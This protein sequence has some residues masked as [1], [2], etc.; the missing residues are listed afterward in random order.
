MAAKEAEHQRSL[1]KKIVRGHLH[2]VLIEQSEARSTVSD[3]QRIILQARS[4][5]LGCGTMHCFD[6]LVGCVIRGSSGV[7]GLFEFV[8]AILKT[9]HFL[10]PPSSFPIHQYFNS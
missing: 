8:Q 7:K 2:V 10:S 6:G 4:L 9:W 1:P 3:F 5:K